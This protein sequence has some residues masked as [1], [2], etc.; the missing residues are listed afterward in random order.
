MAISSGSRPRSPRAACRSARRVHSTSSAWVGSA[1]A[2]SGPVDPC[3][4]PL[5]L[6]GRARRALAIRAGKSCRQVVSGSLAGGPC[7]KTLPPDSPGRARSD[8]ARV[9]EAAMAMPHTAE[10]WHA[11]YQ[12]SNLEFVTRGGKDR[13]GC[14]GC[15]RDSARIRASRH[16]G[17]R[18][19]GGP[20]MATAADPLGSAAVASGRSGRERPVRCQ[21]ARI[22]RGSS[23]IP[24]GSAAR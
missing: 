5:R 8:P 20:D 24:A 17:G 13:I 3:G 22:G 14:P 9:P 21:A 12:V 19:L 23:T 11:R 7:R 15:A 10:I 1:H 2:R 4:Q 18:I 16:A 6:P